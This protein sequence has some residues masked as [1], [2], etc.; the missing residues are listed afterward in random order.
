MSQMGI[1]M[2]FSGVSGVGEE[3]IEQRRGVCGGEGGVGL[4]LTCLYPVA[5]L[6]GEWLYILFLYDVWGLLQS[7]QIE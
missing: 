1:G 7:D 4:D 2:A 5:S 6:C 3:K